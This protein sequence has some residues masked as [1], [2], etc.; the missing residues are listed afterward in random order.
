MGFVFLKV[1][2]FFCVGRGCENCKYFFCYLN[3]SDIRD[4]WGLVFKM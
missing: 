2:G 3:V 1:W 4:F